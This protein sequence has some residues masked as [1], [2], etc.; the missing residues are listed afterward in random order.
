MPFPVF[1]SIATGRYD[2][3]IERTA[4]DEA[5]QVLGAL[6]QMRRSSRS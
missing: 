4:S 6:E 3:V 2:N 1:G 5:G